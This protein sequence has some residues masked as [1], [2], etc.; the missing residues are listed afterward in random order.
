MFRSWASELGRRTKKQYT[1]RSEREGAQ[2]RHRLPD[3]ERDP[4][5]ADLRPAAPGAAEDGAR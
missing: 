5:A 2:R 3:G 1:P 4:E